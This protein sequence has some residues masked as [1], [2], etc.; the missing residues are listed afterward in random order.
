MELGME[1]FRSR[2]A[3]TAFSAE[4]VVRADV[5]EYRAGDVLVAIAQYES[6]DLA[7]V[8]ENADAVRTAMEALRASRDYDL[9]VL[10]ATDIVREGSELFA[11]GKT[12]LAERAFGV[13]LEGGSAWMPGVLSRKKQVAAPLVRA[14]AR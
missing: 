1:L 2:S 14:S 3:G 11:V 4:N 9:V 8:M 7:D 12:R 5:K 10:M 6:V 13:T